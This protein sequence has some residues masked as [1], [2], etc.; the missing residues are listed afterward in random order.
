MLA[1]R[2][3]SIINVSSGNGMTRTKSRTA[4]AVHCGFGGRPVLFISSRGT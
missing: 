2:S 3:G 4:R 1:R